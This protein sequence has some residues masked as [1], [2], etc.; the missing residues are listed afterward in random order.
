[1]AYLGFGKNRYEFIIPE[2]TNFTSWNSICIVIDSSTLSLKIKFNDFN[3]V[4]QIGS[5]DVSRN[6]SSMMVGNFTGRVTDVNVW[7]W[8]LT[9]KQ[10]EEFTYACSNGNSLVK[11]LVPNV[12]Y[13]NNLTILEQGIATKK[14]MIAE[15]DLC[16]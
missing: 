7:S 14:T 13:W 4:T 6:I 12:I 9:N 8:P 5:A 15:N 1:M 16:E 11:R 3:A 10:L 2:Y